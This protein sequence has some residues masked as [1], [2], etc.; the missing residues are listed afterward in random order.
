MFTQVVGE[1]R[2]GDECHPEDKN[3]HKTPAHQE[4][5]IPSEYSR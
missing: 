5:G 2:K 4:G 1:V 3:L